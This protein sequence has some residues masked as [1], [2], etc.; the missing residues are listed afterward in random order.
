MS[1]HTARSVSVGRPVGVCV[2]GR[3]CPGCWS[4][5]ASGRH[6]AG[7]AAGGRSDRSVGEWVCVRVD[8]SVIGYILT[9]GVVGQNLRLILGHT[10]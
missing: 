8:G 7:C 10:G 3:V 4:G 2:C 5:M 9:V 6:I 1:V